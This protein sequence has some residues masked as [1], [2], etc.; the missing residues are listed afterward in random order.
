M[1]TTT[2]STGRE[3][4][5]QAAAAR[6]LDHGFAG[7]S[8]RDIAS[9]C[10]IKAGSIYYHFASKDELLTQILTEGVEA[11]N[12]AFDS[13]AADTADAAPGDRVRAHVDAHLSVLFEG[14]PVTAAHV[15]A[16]RTLPAPA[17]EAVMPIRDA[18]EARWSALLAELRDAGHVAA[19]LDLTLT[20]LTL[21][22]AM[23]FATEWYDPTRGTLERLAD[24]VTRQFWEGVA[25]PSARS[26]TT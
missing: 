3:R 26:T 2:A 16:F 23:N 6:F 14:G 1:S 19:D 25:T 4:I 10:G 12:V 9:D 22:G 20:R 24:T 21:L 13:T 5:V 11:M 7:T 15:S 18:Y 17:R 8:L